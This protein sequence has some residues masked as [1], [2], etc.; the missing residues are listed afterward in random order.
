MEKNNVKTR[1]KQERK[2]ERKK[3]R[4]KKGKKEQYVNKQNNGATKSDIWHRQTD[5][6]CTESQMR[7]VR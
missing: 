5:Q 2:K 3:E 7:G 1:R 4:R 6:N